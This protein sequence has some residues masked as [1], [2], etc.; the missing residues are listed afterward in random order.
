MVDGDRIVRDRR[1]APGLGSTTRIGYDSIRECCGP[2]DL[3]AEHYHNRIRQG[4]VDLSVYWC[5][6]Q[7]LRRGADDVECP[8]VVRRSER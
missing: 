6:R 3:L 2:V 1:H 7:Y 8:L 5:R 4:D